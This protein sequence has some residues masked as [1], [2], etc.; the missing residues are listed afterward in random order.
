[1]HVPN[2]PRLN[3]IEKFSGN[4]FHSAQWNHDYD[5]AGKKVAVIG[6]GASAIQ[7]V[8]E[9][10]DEVAEMHLYQRT[11]AWVMPRKNFAIPIPVRNIF[12]LE[13]RCSLPCKPDRLAKPRPG[14]PPLDDCGRSRPGG[15]SCYRTPTQRRAPEYG[16]IEYGGL[17]AYRLLFI[18]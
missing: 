4:T 9:I 6:T 2:F 14:P 8:S 1:L 13:G 7:F 18:R 15:Q 12:R 3:G 5:L 16:E 10:I 17:P 11:P